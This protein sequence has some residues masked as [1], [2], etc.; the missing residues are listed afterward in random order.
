[1][2][3]DIVGHIVVDNTDVSDT[4]V[5]ELSSSLQVAEVVDVIAGAHSVVGGADVW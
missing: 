5:G 1:M 3:S 2:L 4:A